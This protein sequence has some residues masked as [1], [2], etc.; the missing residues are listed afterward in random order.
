LVL[1]FLPGNRGIGGYIG[2]YILPINLILARLQRLEVRILQKIHCLGIP[3]LNSQASVKI[4]VLLLV[5][6]H[7]AISF[8][9]GIGNGHRRAFAAAGRIRCLY[10][11]PDLKENSITT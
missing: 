5:K 7:T 10:Y 9:S 6:N 3:A 2:I 1:S 11:T 4:Q 8:V